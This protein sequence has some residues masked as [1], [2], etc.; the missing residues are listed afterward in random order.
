MKTEK[1]RIPDRSHVS[2]ETRRLNPAIYGT[3]A[4]IL[5]ATPPL[6]V[7]STK[8]SGKW[9][10]PDLH[11]WQLD[12]DAFGYEVC[13]KCGDRK[14]MGEKPTG[15]FIIHGAPMGKP[16]MTQRDKWAKRP[17]VMRYRAW[18]DSARAAAEGHIPENPLTLS[19]TAYLPIPESWSKAKKKGMAGCF[20]RQKPDRD[21]IDKAVLDA[22]FK[23]DS[24]IAAGTIVKRWDDGNG[25]RIEIQITSL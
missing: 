24:G 2:A 5:T 25:P 15:K 10:R 8:D 11:D 22:L 16:R 14:K 6:A 1:P 18:A 23:D 20:H 13:S 17:A 12:N 3:D 4:P 7:K 21:N 19:W 9:C